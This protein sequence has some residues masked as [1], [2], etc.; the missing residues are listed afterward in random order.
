MRLYMYVRVRFKL[1][2]TFCCILRTYV[3]ET[4][5]GI[6]PVEW[7]RIHLLP[8]HCA[9]VSDAFR[10]FWF[11]RDN[12]WLHPSGRTSSIH[13]K[14]DITPRVYDFSSTSAFFCTRSSRSYVHLNSDKSSL[15]LQIDKIDRPLK[16]GSTNEREREREKK[17]RNGRARIIAPLF[18][19][20]Y[21]IRVYK[22]ANRR[23]RFFLSCNVSS[24]RDD[25]KSEAGPHASFVCPPRVR[26]RESEYIYARVNPKKSRRG[27]GFEKAA[28]PNAEMRKKIGGA[29]E[30]EWVCSSP[31]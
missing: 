8:A 21:T 16:K 10:N 1:F 14:I 18:S 22:Y 31:L 28:L 27:R 26:E 7:F 19:H 2:I 25:K 30:G 17:W 29:M 24:R 11:P 3:Y 23:S 12:T 9:L 6:I 15:L 4:G 20:P 13:R 5:R